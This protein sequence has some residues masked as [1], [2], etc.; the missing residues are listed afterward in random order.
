MSPLDCHPITDIAPSLRLRDVSGIIRST[1][2]SLL[3]PRPVQH[4]HAPNGLLNEKLLGSISSMLIPQS[5]QEKLSENLSSSPP[6]TSTFTSPSAIL[7]T[8]S[9][10]SVSL[11]SIPGLTASLSTTISMLCF[12]FLSRLISS[13]S[14]YML[15]SM[16]ARTNPLLL[17][18]SSSL[19]CSP[20]LPLTTGAKS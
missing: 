20:F 16:I 12:L 18:C 4:G 19:T 13:E 1:S 15:P 9:I 3:N 8:V 17:A 5:G 2:N 10:E 11:F 7:S 6:I 14:S